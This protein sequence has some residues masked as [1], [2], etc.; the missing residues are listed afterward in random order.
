MGSSSG[1]DRLLLPRVAWDGLRE[2][3]R[4]EIAAR[5]DALP[6]VS[7]YR[8]WARRP[9]RLFGA[10]LDAAGP[11]RVADPFGGGGTIAVEAARRK[12]PV[13]VQDLYPWPI[14][15][16]VT[17]LTPVAREAFAEASR[18]LLSAL[19]PLR[20]SYVRQDGRE[21]TH[22]LRVRMG[23]CPRCGKELALFPD[24]LVSLAS[25]RAGETQAYYGC[26]ACGEIWLG[27]RASAPQ[28]CPNC[29][30]VLQIRFARGQL[31]CPLCDH[32]DSASAFLESPPRWRPVLVQEVG[33]K[34]RPRI[35]LRPADPMDPVNVRPA[36][37][38]FQE[39]REPI[40]PGQETN[41]LRSA[42][43]QTWGDLYTERQAAVLLEGLRALAKM[44]DSVRDHLALALLGAAEM[45][46]FLTRWERY[47]PKAIEALAHHRYAHTLL[48][49]ETNLLSTI[50]RGTL[51][52]RLCALQG[53]VEWVHRELGADSFARLLPD[54]SERICPESGIH[55]ALG[56]S[57][58]MALKDGAVD[59][60]LTD[61]PYHD[62]IQYGELA[63]L[64]HFWLRRYR[65]LPDI[66]EGE[67]AVPNRARGNGHED[68]ARILEDC[69]LEC[70]RVLRQGGRLVF[71]FRNR[72]L[73]AWQ[74]LC[75]ALNRAGFRIHAI[76]VIQ[77]DELRDPTRKGSR[78]L[79]HDLVLECMGLEAPAPN[80]P[81]VHVGQGREERAL[82]AAGLA[83]AEALRKGQSERL[84]E[85]FR[86]W[87]R[88]LGPRERAWIQQ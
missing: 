14:F 56:S 45:P 42:G 79:R 62:D 65:E 4:K 61:P 17:A 46:A 44:E 73:Q 27:P 5:E 10:I 30:R 28:H 87:R 3:I 31:R 21:L 36:S 39:L 23:R 80:R 63:R 69:F 71:T 13:Y 6:V 9:G 68:Y 54:L 84:P 74:A 34:P 19:E 58:R 53:V 75:N 60:I 88:R 64:F 22:I 12:L 43:F 7:A 24:P 82:L 49:V 52:R 86:K 26:A 33:P 57:A 76:A 55:L 8:W 40:P 2:Q 70:R 37:E 47:H 11:V 25:R 66:D 81:F 50:G 20:K 15:G 85:I 16:M 77:T 72:E 48:A 83:M 51:P 18:K 32:S 67:E 41:R 29:R 1:R 78:S 35:I 59:L 38:V